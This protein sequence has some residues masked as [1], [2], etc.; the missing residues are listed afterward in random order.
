MDVGEESK[1]GTSF[2]R[3]ITYTYYESNSFAIK[4]NTSGVR[5][6][7][8]PWLTGDL[9]FANQT[10]LFRGQKKVTGELNIDD[11]AQ[12]T[13][14]IVLTQS[15]DDHCHLPTL[16]RLPKTI[17]VAASPSAADRIRP[18]GYKTVTPIDHDE[19]KAFCDGALKIRATQG[20]LVGPPWSKRQNGYIMTETSG[21]P[22]TSVYYEPHCDFAAFSLRNVGE[23]DVV[24]SPVNSTLLN[25]GL[26]S[27][28]LTQGDIN[29]SQLLRVLKPKVLVPLL[30]TDINTDGALTSLLSYRGQWEGLKE[31]LE[32]QGILVR[33]DLPA[34]PG[35]AL[36]IAL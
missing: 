5:V 8:D 6:L 28:P 24:I 33:V 9:T 4:F 1:S 10:W 17:P 14:L 36:A 11:I 27:Y 26:G 31:E 30:N 20:A 34:V 13:D 19:E 25:M 22:P 18:L 23:V 12:E 32:Q 15:L 16:E 7:V 29:L 2:H 21:S 3:G 35:E